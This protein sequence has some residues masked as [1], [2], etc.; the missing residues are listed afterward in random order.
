MTV[1]ETKVKAK[2]LP[3]GASALTGVERAMVVEHLPLVDRVVMG[4]RGKLAEH[5]DLEEL[6]SVGMTGLIAAVRNFDA[7]RREAF[8]GYAVLRIRG[9]VMDELRRMD[10]MTRGARR[11]QKNLHEEVEAM[12][13]ELGRAPTDEELRKRLK[14]SQ[15]EFEKL[16]RQTRS[17]SF[18]SLDVASVNEEGK[19][20][21]MQ[22]RIA[23]RNQEQ[24]NE[25]MEREEMLEMLVDRM[26]KLPDRQK[27]VL[28]FYYHE[29]LKLSEIASIFEVSEARICQ[30][31]MQALDTLR[32]LMP[33][34]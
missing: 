18:I 29:G 30:I 10:W 25:A 33:G 24:G 13:Q 31:H 8:K 19:D 3:K 20:I 5:A 26:E 23:D 22:E 27:K 34:R 9:A 11:K 4:M 28:A 32:Q 6:K 7:R 14:M 17:M 15:K 21:P 2:G 12:E 1:K 16:K